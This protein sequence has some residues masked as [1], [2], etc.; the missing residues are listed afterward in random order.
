MVKLRRL[1]TKLYCAFGGNWHSALF[2]SE[3]L[4]EAGNVELGIRVD[5]EQM[6]QKLL[7][8]FN[9]IYSHSIEIAKD[10]LYV[11]S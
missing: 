9:R 2:G 10:E 1:H 6:T 11:E 4:T 8:Y 7:S 3:N 5:D